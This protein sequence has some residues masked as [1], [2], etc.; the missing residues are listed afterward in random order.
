MRKQDRLARSGKVALKFANTIKDNNVYLFFGDKGHCDL[1][2]YMV[3]F[4]F[5]I[6]AMV[7]ELK[8]KAQSEETIKSL[9]RNAEEGKVN[10]N[11]PLGYFT[12]ASKPY[13]DD[14]EPILVNE[15]FD[16][17]LA[18]DGT[19]LIANYLNDEGIPTKGNKNTIWEAETVK[20][21][22]K[23]KIILKQINTTTSFGLN[24]SFFC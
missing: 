9:K 19:R 14:E 17:Y 23:N 15:I 8:P 24:V 5:G 16:K 11:I 12:K 18:G 2:D 3:Y 13:K 7:D 20:N 4:H 21:I 6:M 10:G 1:N 22:L